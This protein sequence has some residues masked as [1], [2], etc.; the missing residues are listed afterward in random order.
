MQKVETRVLI[1]EGDL[2]PCFTGNGKENLIIVIRER[3]HQKCR[4]TEDKL[5]ALG[6]SQLL[7]CQTI[8]KGMFLY[9]NCICSNQ[10]N[11]YFILIFKT[12]IYIIH[13][14]SNYDFIDQ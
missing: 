2:F 12:I 4:T 10:K 3:T 14:A 9:N 6:I 11:R 1:C 8:M 5:Q 13:T 7:Q